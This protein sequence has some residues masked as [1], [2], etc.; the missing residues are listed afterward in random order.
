MRKPLL[1]HKGDPIYAIG[2]GKEYKEGYDRIKWEQ[3]TKRSYKVKVN[4]KVID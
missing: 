3:P 2:G 1:D 4:G